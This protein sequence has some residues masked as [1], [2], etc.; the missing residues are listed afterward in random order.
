MESIGLL[1]KDI[2]NLLDVEHLNITF[3]IV[4]DSVYN[5]S[6]YFYE[7][8]GSLIFS[9]EE[10]EGIS[11]ENSAIIRKRLSSFLYGN[12]NTILDSKFNSC[13]LKINNDGITKIHMDYINIYDY[14]QVLDS[15]IVG[16]E[17]CGYRFKE[18]TYMDKVFESIYGDFELEK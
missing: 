2:K 13:I 1:I 17:E 10:Y 9:G 8:N 16:Y 3:K 18:G 6:F 7:K 4:E 15:V 11:I 12:L 14:N 5:S